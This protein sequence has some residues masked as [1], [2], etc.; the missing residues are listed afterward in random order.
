MKIYSMEVK[1]VGFKNVYEIYD[2]NEIYLKVKTKGIKF[3]IDR[4]IGSI[5]SIGHKFFIQT[6]E[7][8][9]YITIKKCVGFISE[10]YDI[11]YK[12]RKIGQIKRIVKS[13]EPKF[14]ILMGED[15]YEINGDVMGEN[16]IINKDHM[17]IGGISKKRFKIQD[18]YNIQILEGKYEKLMIASVICIDNS[19]HN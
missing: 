14:I 10:K 11:L 15:N 19:I 12:E 13:M 18:K 9:E 17:N 5:C 6:T 3:L 16:F 1:I 8:T 2:E 4:F 7:G